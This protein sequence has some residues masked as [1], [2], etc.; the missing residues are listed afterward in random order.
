MISISATISH[1]FKETCTWL[2]TVFPHFMPE[3]SILSVVRQ[4]L[5]PTNHTFPQ[6]L[7]LGITLLQASKVAFIISICN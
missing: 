5:I 6:F 1:V 2:T 7:H 4:K 3:D